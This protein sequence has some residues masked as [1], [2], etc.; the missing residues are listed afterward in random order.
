VDCAHLIGRERDA[1]DAG[2]SS[3]KQH[4]HSQ[5]IESILFVLMM[6]EIK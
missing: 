3:S 1:D 4:Y 6:T 2:G 5:L